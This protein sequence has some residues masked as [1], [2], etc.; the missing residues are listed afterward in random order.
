MYN[1]LHRP[2]PSSAKWISV[3]FLT[4]QHHTSSLTAKN[5]F[6]ISN[7]SDI[8]MPINKSHLIYL[9]FS[10]AEISTSSGWQIVY[11]SLWPHLTH[12]DSLANIYVSY[13]TSVLNIWFSDNETLFGVHP[14]NWNRLWCSWQKKREDFVWIL[15]WTVWVC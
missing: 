10:P 6:N 13:I 4:V 9:L 11:C 3:W 2:H 5:H 7:S 15:N 14:R 8:I 1:T 12:F